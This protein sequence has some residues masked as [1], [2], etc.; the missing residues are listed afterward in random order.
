MR[1]GNVHLPLAEIPEELEKAEIEV[2]LD[3]LRDNAARH[4]LSELRELALAAGYRASVVERAVEEFEGEPRPAPEPEPEPPPVRV[5]AKR[6]RTKPVPAAVPVAPAP[7]P[8]Q[9]PVFREEP[10]AIEPSTQAASAQ[11]GSSVNPLLALLIVIL[12]AAVLSLCFTGDQGL[13]LFFYAAEFGLAFLLAGLQ[14]IRSGQLTEALQAE[15]LVDPVQNALPISSEPD[16]AAV[17]TLPHE[18]Q[19]EAP[20][21]PSVPTRTRSRR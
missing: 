12:N 19:T 16:R 9:T 21:T 10:A 18:V 11:A 5:E 14:K 6:E 15:Q 13:A 4:E 8:P 20:Q 1:E 2:L 7:P 17:P 3:Y